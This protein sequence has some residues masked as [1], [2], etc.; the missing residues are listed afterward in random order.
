L[1]IKLNF[2]TKLYDENYYSIIETEA[3]EK[4]PELYNLKANPSDTSGI[5]LHKYN[6]SV[7][8]KTWLY[9]RFDSK[10]EVFSYLST[11]GWSLVTT[12]SELEDKNNHTIYDS[13]YVP[14]YE[15]ITFYIFEKE[16]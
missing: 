7:T 15:Q 2:I 13:V 3:T 11:Y 6:S 1:I 12:Y 9:N 5:K 16:N 10:V 14:R 8:N 4:V